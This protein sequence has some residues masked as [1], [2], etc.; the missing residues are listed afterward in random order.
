MTWIVIIMK[1]FYDDSNNENTL[2]RGN[3]E[4]EYS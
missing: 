2:T 3:Y 1:I 4:L